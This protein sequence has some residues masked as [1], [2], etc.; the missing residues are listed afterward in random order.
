M[1]YTA[2]R[3]F[4][5]YTGV[6]ALVC[7]ARWSTSVDCEAFASASKPMISTSTKFWASFHSQPTS[8]SLLTTRHS[9]ASQSAR[10]RQGSLLPLVP[11][12]DILN[13]IYWF[14]GWNSCRTSE[15]GGKI[16][17]LTLSGDSP[18][19]E[20]RTVELYTIVISSWPEI[21]CLMLFVQ[22][23]ALITKPQPIESKRVNAPFAFLLV[24][25]FPSF[26]KGSNR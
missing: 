8:M 15:S 21:T 26:C 25:T 2:C 5:K 13:R 10:V 19:W 4:Y 18:P 22:P 9:K 16:R 7:C 3:Y 12:H 14:L 23:C 11:Q 6:I 20:R 17:W 1:K 24:G